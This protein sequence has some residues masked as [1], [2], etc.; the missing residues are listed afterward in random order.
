MNWKFWKI[1]EKRSTLVQ[2]VLEFQHKENTGWEPILKSAEQRADFN[3]LEHVE[4]NEKIKAIQKG[5][6]LLVEAHN[7][8]AG[9]VHE[10]IAKKPK[11][12]AKA[13]RGRK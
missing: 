5:L 8:L 10:H 13:R 9:R 12:K 1:F 6:D 2:E 4:F 11:K 7:K 3:Y